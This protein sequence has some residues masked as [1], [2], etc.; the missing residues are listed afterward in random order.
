MKPS[1]PEAEL[2]AIYTDC[3]RDDSYRMGG[4]RLRHMLASVKTHVDSLGT[5]RLLTMLDVGCGRGEL[6]ESVK[7]EVPTIHKFRGRE[8]VPDLCYEPTVTLI[9]SIA[10]MPTDE[11]F[12]IV[13]CA[14]VLEHIPPQDTQE[15]L[16]RLWECVSSGS[17][18]L[19]L[20]VAWFPHLWRMSDGTVKELHINCRSYDEWY[21]LVLQ[22][23]CIRS[24]FRTDFGNRTAQIAVRKA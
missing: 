20:N 21:G 22:L 3:Y 19:I 12:D 2:R 16:R 5:N 15:A 11:Q 13:T 10:S 18:V 23:P 17:G 8:I 6:L 1:T 4:F 24:T 14:D 9:D 7:K